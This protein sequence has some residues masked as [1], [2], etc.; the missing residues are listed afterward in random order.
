MRPIAWQIPE[1]WKADS[2]ENKVANCQQLEKKTL[3]TQE[4]AISH[5]HSKPLKR[6]MQPEVC[7]VPVRAKGKAT[8]D[9][10]VYEASLEMLVSP[11]C[12]CRWRAATGESGSR[13]GRIC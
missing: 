8:G 4:V 12:S 5:S 11:I 10:L 2:H 1:T 6:K 9:D 3:L 13:L 7:Y